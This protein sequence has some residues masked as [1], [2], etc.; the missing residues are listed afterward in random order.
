MFVQRFVIIACL[1]TTLATAQAIPD[2]GVTV[3]AAKPST[4]PK[5]VL[6]ASLA[7]LGGSATTFPQTVVATATYTASPAGSTPS[8]VQL[9]A[10]GLGQYR[11]DSTGS[12]TTTVVLNGLSGK[13]QRNGTVTPLSVSDVVG[14]GAEFVPVLL[15][16]RW[17]TATGTTLTF[18]GAETLNGR[19]VNHIIVTPASSD[20]HISHSAR[21]DIYIDGTNNLPVRARVY[22]YPSDRQF[23]ASP[24]LTEGATSSPTTLN[25]VSL[26]K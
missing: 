19:S 26:Q 13:Q 10:L 24:C 14:R 2:A 3:S 8:S 22:R 15:L 9:K 21:C 25:L 11:I 7:A 23:S 4:D 6:Q 17:L 20:S 18:V 5:A 1:A 16:A 12:T